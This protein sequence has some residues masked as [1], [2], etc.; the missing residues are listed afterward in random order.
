VEWVDQYSRRPYR[1]TTTG[2][3]GDR[4]TA[5]VKSYHDVLVDYEFHPESKCADSTGDPCGKQTIGLLQ[6]RHI[7]IDQI[8]PIGKESNNL[9]EVESGLEHSAQNVYTEYPTDDATSGKRRLCQL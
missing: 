9:E 5:R 4:R 3:H 7:Q 2:H 6:R 1:I 8:K